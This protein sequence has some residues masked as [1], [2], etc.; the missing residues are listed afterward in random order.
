MNHERLYQGFQHSSAN[1]Q[2]RPPQVELSSTVPEP[3]GY[4]RTFADEDNKESMNQY[5][6]KMASDPLSQPSIVPNSIEYL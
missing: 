4:A 6:E 5:G 2:G 1:H 3:Q